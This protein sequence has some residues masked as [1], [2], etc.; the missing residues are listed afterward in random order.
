MADSGRFAWPKPLMLQR[1][2]HGLHRLKAKGVVRPRFEPPIGGIPMRFHGVRLPEG[3]LILNFL[4]DFVVE[5]G[6]F[7]VYVVMQMINTDRVASV[8]LHLPA[9]EEDA[10]RFVEG[11][12]YGRFYQALYDAGLII[13]FNWE[14]WTGC[15]QVYINRPKLISEADLET[16]CKLLTTHVRNDRFCDGHLREMMVCGHVAAVLRRLK[17]LTDATDTVSALRVCIHRGSHQIGGTCV[18]LAC[19]GKHLVLDI[20]VPLDAADP[21]NVEMP[22]VSGLSTEDP[23]LLGI[24]ISHPH[25]DHYGL[26]SL[27]PKGTKFLMGAATERLLA[28]AADFTPSG[29]SFDHVTHLIDRKPIELGPFRIIP[30][31]MDHSAYDAYAVLVEAGG[32][33]LVY[34]GDLRGHGRKA[35]LFERLLAEPPTDVDV[36]LM[37]GTTITRIG[38]DAGFPTEPDLETQ[39]VKLFQETPGMP[40]VW[41]SGQNIDRLVSVFRAAKR[42]GRQ[43]ILDMYT[44]HVL[45][46]TENPR[47]PQSHWAEVR[48]FLPW[49]QKQR[50]I[51]DESFEIANRYRLNR[52]YPEQLAAVASSSVMLFRPSMRRDLEKADCLGRACLVYSMW[53]GYLKDKKMK[54]FLAWL[55]DNNIPMH[56]IHTSGHATVKDLQRLRQAFGEAVVV[57]IHTQQPDL[58]EETFGNVRMHSDG[59]W[60]RVRQEETHEVPTRAK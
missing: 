35:R 13:Q 38:A 53:D 60:W 47:L 24:I 15:A 8:L 7:Y 29:G 40:L 58:Y 16:L 17:V 2:L 5:S 9:I 22:A 1:N 39:M 45:A 34:T 36:L 4:E 6:R 23:A 14:Q 59:E 26:A 30:Y 31:L 32:N 50:I 27:V 56:R 43:L 25:Q 33:R 37:E 52:I 21:S 19:E 48:V 55:D 57:P 11:D 42:S 3:R 20:G 49:S 54:P 10:A 28:A 44:A 51:K 12:A 18:E 46:A 41:C